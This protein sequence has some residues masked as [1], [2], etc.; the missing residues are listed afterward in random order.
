MKKLFCIIL[1]SIFSLA[2][3]SPISV[4]AVT[5]IGGEVAPCACSHSNYVS[6]YYYTYIHMDNDYHEVYRTER[7]RCNACNDIF[8]IGNPEA[9]PLEMHTGSLYY[10]RSVHVGLPAAH[11]YVNGGTCELCHEYFERTHKAY[12]TSAGCVEVNSHV[13]HE[14]H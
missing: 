3:I 5:E 12:C 7:R 11:Y 9:L 4:F 8:Y 10:V 14:K 6:S 1:V 2:T 13:E